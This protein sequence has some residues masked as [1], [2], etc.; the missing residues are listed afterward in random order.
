MESNERVPRKL[1]NFSARLKKRI[2][3]HL[4]NYSNLFRFCVTLTL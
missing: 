4:V 1:I 2:Y 3:L